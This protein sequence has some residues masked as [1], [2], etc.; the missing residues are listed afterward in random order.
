MS[1]IVLAVLLFIIHDK[2][3]WNYLPDRRT[4]SA[5]IAYCSSSMIR[6]IETVPSRLTLTAYN[7][8]LFIIHDKKDWNYNSGFSTVVA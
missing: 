5:R 3:D 4:V 7:I 6:R 1:A 2:K 8:L